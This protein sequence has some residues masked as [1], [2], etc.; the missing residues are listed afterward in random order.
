MPRQRLHVA[1]MKGCS[2]SA[3][4]IAPQGRIRSCYAPRSGSAA[5]GAQGVEDDGEVDDLLE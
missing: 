2:T 3:N 5:Q 1:R 4:E